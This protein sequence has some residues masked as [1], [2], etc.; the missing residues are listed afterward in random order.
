MI[1][2]ALQKSE[3]ASVIS[4]IASVFG[5]VKGPSAD[6]TTQPVVDVMMSVTDQVNIKKLNQIFLFFYFMYL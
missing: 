6:W 3:R 5:A 2:G 1:F 4:R